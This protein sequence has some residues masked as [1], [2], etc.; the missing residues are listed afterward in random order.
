MGRS[1]L[2]IAGFVLLAVSSIHASDLEECWLEGNTYNCCDSFTVVFLDYKICGTAKYWY[3]EE[4]V[5]ITL[6][7]DDKQWIERN[8]AVK[9][10]QGEH[11]ERFL[12][13]GFYVN[14]Y[15]VRREGTSL[16]ICARAKITALFYTVWEKQQCFTLASK[17]RERLSVN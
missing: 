11:S 6:E 4:A 15:E 3:E 7:I 13:F 17:E 14:I 2:F 8:Y 16:Y 10:L 12:G 9:D 1:I 5:E